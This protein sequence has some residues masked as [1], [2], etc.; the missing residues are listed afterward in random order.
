MSKEL[1]VIKGLPG[2]KAALEAKAEELEAAAVMVVAEEVEVIRAD[3]ERGAPELT[4]DLREHIVGEAHGTR[5]RIRSTSRHA[6]FVEHGTFK[7]EAQP[8]MG[9][10]ADRA[11]PRFPKRAADIIR[12][13]LGG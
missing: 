13:A 6:G 11:R 1:V 8:Y 10:A 5:G 2:L 12:A 4:G 9:P 7:D 3:A